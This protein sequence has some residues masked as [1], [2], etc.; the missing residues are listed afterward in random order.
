MS[1]RDFLLEIGLE[2]LPARFVTNAMNQ[3]RDKVADW[4]ADNRISFE[5][6]KAYSTPRRLA[7]IVNG[8]SEKQEDVSD[9]ARGPAKKIA[10]DDEGNWTKAAQGFARGQ[11]VDPSAIFFKEVKGTEYVFVK[12]YSEGQ[13]TFSLLSQLKDVITNVTFPKNMRWGTNQLRYARPIKWIICLFG[14]KT[15]PF[16]ITNVQTGIISQGHRFLGEQIMIEEP[17]QYVEKLQEQY[18]IVDAHARKEMIRHQFRQLEEENGWSIGVDESLLEEVNNLVEYPT[19]LFGGFDQSF[20]ELP[21]EVLITSMKE[22]QR[23][24]PVKNESGQLLPYF[25]TVRNGNDYALDKVAKGNEK[26]LRARLADGQFFYEEDQKMTIE[27]ALKRLDSTVFHEELGTIGDKVR[28]IRN[29]SGQISSLAEVSEMIQGKVD[30][31][32]AICKFDLVTNMVYEFTELQ[33]VMGEKYARMFGEDETVA[34]AVNEHYMPRSA[35]DDLPT[36]ETGA[37]VSIADKLDTI[38]GCYGIGLIP[39]GSQDPYAL[40][41]QGAGIMQILIQ[42]EWSFHFEQLLQAAVKQMNNLQLLKRD[43]N[44]VQRELIDFF[45]LRLKNILQEKGIRYDV[46]DAVLAG[47]IEMP[48]ITLKKA[49]LLNAKLDEIAFKEMVAALSRITNISKKA[50]HKTYNVELFEQKQEHDLYKSYELVAQVLT[51]AIENG[52]VEAA[53]TNLSSLKP[54]IDAYFDNIMVMDDD[55]KVRENRLGFMKAISETIVSFAHFN[56]IVF[57]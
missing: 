8:V 46:I 6:I 44:E 25:I 11:G 42:K 39:S 32:A 47:P 24:F 18:V 16:Q 20:L 38:V 2:E 13:A 53:F 40:R 35:N 29:L 51:E 1:K 22:H 34:K 30:R 5:D 26:V 27:S 21:E 10:L 4:M 14:E 56:E 17:S 41:R 15:V 33:G 7:V 31:A 50:D 12:T 49:E 36:S 55:E 52:D 37:I 57:K 3:L 43:S 19:A 28:R 54:S 45:K 9:E 23:Y 48:H